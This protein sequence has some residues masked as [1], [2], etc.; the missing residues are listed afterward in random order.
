MQEDTDTM[1]EEEWSEAKRVTDSYE[2][3]VIEEQ[4][5][6]R[7]REEEQTAAEF[8]TA[9]CAR[10]RK[11]ET[12]EK[13]QAELRE[14]P[15]ATYAAFKRFT[16]VVLSICGLIVFLLPMLLIAI[17]I[18]CESKGP[19]IFKTERVGKNG[20]YFKFYKFRSMRT[21]APRDCAPSKLDSEQYITRVGKFLRRTS[22]DELPQL[23]CILRGDMSIIGPRPAGKSEV[24]L[25]VL[26][27]RMRADRLRPGLSG[28]AQVNGRDITAADIHLKAEYDA[29]YTDHCSFALD[30]KIFWMTLRKVFSGDGIVEGKHAGQIVTDRLAAAEIAADIQQSQEPCETVRDGETVFLITGASKSVLWFRKELIG[31]LRKKGYRVAVV[32][33]D[34]EHETEIIGLG[35]DFYCIE[36]DNR[37]T[38]IRS[39]LRY[40]KELK[41]LLLAQKPKYAMTFQAKANTFGVWACK[42]AKIEHV[43]SMVEGLGTVYQGGGLKKAIVRA[44]SDILYRRAFRYARRVVFLNHD[45]CRFM[46]ARG[47]VKEVRTL[48]LPGIGLDLTNYPFAPMPESDQIR[49]VMVARAEIE[50]GVEEYCKAAE[51]VKKIYPDT[52]FDYF[53][54]DGG[55]SAILSEYAQKGVVR[56]KGYTEKICEA[57]VNYHVVVLPTSYGEGSPR[58][59]MEAAALGRVLIGTDI[60]GC[61]N[62]VLDGENGLLVR[63]K[64]YEDLAEKMIY[65]ID[66]AELLPEWGRASRKLA[67]GRFDS[68]VID[69][70][71]IGLLTE[72]ID[73]RRTK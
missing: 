60:S 41:R 72:K 28:W 63:K 67:E 35:V 13:V 62:S 73:R 3:I 56:Y 8:F 14:C 43:V 48:L 4:K 65:L 50:K 47:T 38:G 54:D 9:D 7:T 32:S 70:A 53:G 36:G 16:D 26:R 45:D 71:L 49:F 1:T 18:K 42:K 17:I 23:L 2:G 66:H 25:N 19:A 31:D 21:D 11:Y 57:L 39:N 29:Y 68:H 20:R 44:V 58:S 24:E 5:D 27:H 30:W 34:A 59:L 61:R 69:E 6:K 46:I 10:E 15:R 12:G 22:L 64:D 40:V 37:D 33:C 51:A 52:V 55:A